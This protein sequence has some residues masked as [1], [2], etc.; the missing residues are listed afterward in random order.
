MFKTLFEK[1]TNCVGGIYGIDLNLVKKN[2]KITTCNQ[3]DLDTSLG[4]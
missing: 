1:I 4:F 2:R 3:L